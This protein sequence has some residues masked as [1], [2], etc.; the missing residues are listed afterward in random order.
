MKEEKGSPDCV[1]FSD[2][3]KLNL[4]D[5]Q[6]AD[7]GPLGYSSDVRPGETVEQAFDRVRGV[8]EKQIFAK[9]TRIRKGLWH[10]VTDR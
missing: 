8:V 2:G 1:W 5:Y 9:A 4:G 3:L 10:K 6:S 7:V